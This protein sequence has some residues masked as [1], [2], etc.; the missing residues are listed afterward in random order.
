MR[1]SESLR[2]LV[3]P[4]PV[5]S[6]PIEVSA[7]LVDDLYSALIS[8]AIAAST[9]VLVGGIAASR[10]GSPSLMF[11]TAATAAIAARARCS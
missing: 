5:D 3:K 8:F 4:K 10:T 7:A 9:A 1:L 11:L 2:W 6:V